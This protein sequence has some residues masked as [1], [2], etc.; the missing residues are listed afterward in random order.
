[1]LI[2]FNI[3]AAWTA[4]SVVA[5]LAIAPAMSTR[6]REVNFYSQDK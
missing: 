5:G 6:L 2:I 4:V 1:V 3:L